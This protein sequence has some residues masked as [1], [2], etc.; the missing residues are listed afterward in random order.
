MACTMEQMNKNPVTDSFIIFGGTTPAAFLASPFNT[1]TSTW[2]LFVAG[3][4][5]GAGPPIALDLTGQ[6]NASKG[7][8]NPAPLAA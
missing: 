2:D 3:A 8:P 1:C 4:L 6:A 7:K 5:P